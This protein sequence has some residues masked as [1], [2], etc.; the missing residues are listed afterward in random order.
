ML[1]LGALF[2]AVDAA[3]QQ[4]YPSRPVRFIVPFPPGGS[5][6]PMARMAAQRLADKWGQPVIVENRPGGNTIIGT[7]AVAKAPADGYT[8]LLASPPFVVNPSLLPS[9]PYD[10]VKD[11]DAVATIAKARVILVLHPSLP[12]N[13]LQEFIAFAKS[14]PGQLNYASP[15]SGGIIH[16]ASELFNNMAGTKIQ[17]IPYKGSGALMPDLLSGQVQLSFQIPISVIAHI[18]SEKLKPIA[19]TG[20]TRLPALPEVP[21]FAEAGLPNYDAEAWFGIAAPV[22]VPREII[23]KISSEMKAMLNLPDIREFLAKQGNE[24]FISTPEQFAALV[25]ADVAKYA[26]IVKAANIKPEN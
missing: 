7:E 21:T 26:R 19:I 4:A 15:G 18:K 23:N 2:T 12:A 17:H 9:L 8:I 3:A 16:L 14:K 6:D 1:V 13:S 10:T 20:E 11:F 5:T 25:K 24:A 22:G